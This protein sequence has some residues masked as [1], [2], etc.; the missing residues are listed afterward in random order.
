MPLIQAKDKKISFCAPH[1]YDGDYDHSRGEAMGGLNLDSVLQAL[2][3]R[4]GIV[5][6]GILLTFQCQA[7][8]CFATA[9]VQNNVPE[10]ILKA[11]AQVESNGDSTAISSNAD[12]SQNYGLMQIHESWLPSLK[13][14][15]GFTKTTLLEPCNN[16][17]VGA[18]ILAGNLRRYNNDLWR[19]VGFYNAKSTNLQNRYVKKVRSALWLSAA[20]DQEEF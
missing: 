5:I 2:V 20:A 7:N 3:C 4:A 16:I 15:F 17:K 12:G 18:W 13:R 11:I 9:A 10:S 8:A 1:H 14:Q 19:A 6:F